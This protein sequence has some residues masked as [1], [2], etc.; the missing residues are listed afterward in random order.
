MARPRIGFLGMGAMGGPMARRLVQQGFSVT[1]YDVSAP[2]A[3]A[4]TKDG[5]APAASPAAA[6]AAADVVLSSLPHPAAVRSAYLGP[7]G[8]V[9]ALRAGTLLIDLFDFESPYGILGRWFNAAYLTGYMRRLL[10][11]RNAFLKQTAES[12]RWKHLLN[13]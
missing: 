11:A 1:G 5:V 6:A 3:A 4:A 13:R 10:E 8:A 7:D 2:R 12:G 9:P